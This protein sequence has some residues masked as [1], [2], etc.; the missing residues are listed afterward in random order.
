MFGYFDG[1]NFILSQ[2][3][4]PPAEPRKPC[5]LIG[6][7]VGQG[8]QPT[9]IAVLEKFKPPSQLAAY[10]CRYL[11]RWLPPDTAY[12]KLRAELALMLNGPL[13]ECHLI[14]EAG[15]SI[16]AV[17]TMLRRHQLNAY[18]RGIELKASAVD[19][20]CGD[21]WNVSKGL[22]IET[23]RQVLQEERLVFDERMPSQVAATTPPVQTIYQ[24][25]LNYPYNK[26]PPANEAFA[27]R[28]GEY[29]DLVL[30]VALA[31]WFGDRHMRVVGALF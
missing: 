25:I 11:R 21:T 29:D 31:C 23:T 17:I 13:A 15:P 22:V 19:D 6:L 4:Q 18:I 8:G 26:T 3:R 10:E 16:G 1:R 7:S 20:R 5:F 2:A 27:S 14:V 12:P 24:A 9:G 28:D 30:P